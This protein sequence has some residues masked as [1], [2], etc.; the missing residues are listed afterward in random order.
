M[1][2]PK[3]TKPMKEYRGLFETGWDC[4]DSSCK[5]AT[6]A[7]DVIITVNGKAC[8][9]VESVPIEVKINETI[10]DD[11]YYL[12]GFRYLATKIQESFALEI[13]KILNYTPKTA[14]MEDLDRLSGIFSLERYVGEEEDDFNFRV[15]AYKDGE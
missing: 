3:C 8:T 10:P 6:T 15:K 14:T 9:S 2:C 5:T 1:N 11:D 12:D 13:E 7:V 4:T